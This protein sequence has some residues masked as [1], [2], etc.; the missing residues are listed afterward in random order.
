MLA[1]GQSHGLVAAPDAAEP[2]SLSASAK[3][4]IHPVLIRNEHNPVLRVTRPPHTASP[5][6]I[7][8]RLDP[9]HSKAIS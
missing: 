8:G 9:A 4:F 6:H 7:Q 1:L 5:H 3:R 2:G